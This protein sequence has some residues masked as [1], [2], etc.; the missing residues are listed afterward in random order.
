M[1][2]MHNATLHNDVVRQSSIVSIAL[3]LIMGIKKTL[4]NTKNNKKFKEL[5]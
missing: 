5:A 3:L 4:K 1:P 2:I